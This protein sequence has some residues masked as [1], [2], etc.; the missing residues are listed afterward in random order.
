MNLES[1]TPLE[2]PACTRIAT[3][4]NKLNP[5]QSPTPACD[6]HSYGDVEN[7]LG[8]MDVTP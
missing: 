5:S 4:G 8:G 6:V 7:A 3:A 2:T 1:F